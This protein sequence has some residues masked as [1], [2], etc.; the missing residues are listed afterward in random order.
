MI[1]KISILYKLYFVYFLNINVDKFNINCI[2]LIIDFLLFI[3]VL[4]GENMKD[5]WINEGTF[6]FSN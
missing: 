1:L 3:C 2:I 5:L 6:W 4:Y